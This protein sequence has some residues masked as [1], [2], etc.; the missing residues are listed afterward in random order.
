LASKEEDDDVGAAMLDVFLSHNI[1][2]FFSL[3]LHFCND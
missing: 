1:L 3:L 2:E